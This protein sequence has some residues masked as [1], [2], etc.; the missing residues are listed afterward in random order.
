[1]EL[2]SIIVKQEKYLSKQRYLLGVF[3]LTMVSVDVLLFSTNTI[4]SLYQQPTS[5]AWNLQQGKYKF[6]KKNLIKIGLCC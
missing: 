3:E 2:V 6:L 1:M 4:P 5:F